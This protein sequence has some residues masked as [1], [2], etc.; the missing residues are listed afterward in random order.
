MSSTGTTASR[1]LGDRLLGGVEK[2]GNR[3]CP[4]P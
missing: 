2:W 1:T 4:I 3:L